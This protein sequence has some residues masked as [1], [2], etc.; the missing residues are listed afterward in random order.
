MELGETLEDGTTLGKYAEALNSVGI[1]IKNSNGELK[2]MDAILNEM[3]ATWNTLNNA[4]KVALAQNVAGTRQYTQLIALMDN[5]ET[6]Q[7]NLTTAETSAGKLESQQEIY[8]DSLEAHL[9]QLST[10]A[11]KFYDTLLDEKSIKGFVDML[12][13]ALKGINTYLTGLGDNLT[14]ILGGNVIALFSKQLGSA[15]ARMNNNFDI[16][17][18]NRDADAFKQELANNIRND[19][20][21]N[22]AESPSD[23]R[24]QAEAKYSLDLLQIRQ[25]IS[26][27][28]YEELATQQQIYGQLSESIGAAEN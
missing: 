24:V 13:G 14:G 23:E 22:G 16:E 27:E 2:T 17:T 3:G 15:A 25:N 19:Y 18:K 8:L 5:W 21:L 12:T 11:E 1:S 7:T 28:D 9:Q 10:E 4:Q 20:E 6:F 26:K